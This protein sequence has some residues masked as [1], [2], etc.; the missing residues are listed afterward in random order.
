MDAIE[1]LR[2]LPLNDET[3]RLVDALAE[4]N[5]RLRKVEEAAR[6][7]ESEA[8][9]KSDGAFSD[10]GHF[11]VDA[12]PMRRLSAALSPREGEG[13]CPLP[14]AQSGHALPACVPGKG[15]NVERCN[16]CHFESLAA[17]TPESP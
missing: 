3:R 12:G 8:A 1:R 7:V 17:P 11:E 5:A 16:A 4:E 2:S 14:V 10:D 6:E 13:K 9:Y 15:L